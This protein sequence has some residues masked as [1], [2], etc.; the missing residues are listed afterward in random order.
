MAPDAT[1]TL[2]GDDATAL[3]QF[4]TARP[5]DEVVVDLYGPPRPRIE[6]RWGM[7]SPMYVAFTLSAPTP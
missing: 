3:A 6:L 5:Q 7:D 1:L 2:K 4:L